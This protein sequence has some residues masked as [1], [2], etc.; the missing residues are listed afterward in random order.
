MAPGCRGPEKDAVIFYNS[1][2]HIALLNVYHQ[3][4]IKLSFKTGY[5]V[6]VNVPF[7]PKIEGLNVSPTSDTDGNK[8]CIVSDL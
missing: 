5:C 8:F 3:I 6:N 7:S 1:Q 2:T 4:T